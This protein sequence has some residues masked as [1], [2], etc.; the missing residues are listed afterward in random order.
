[1]TRT[2]TAKAARSRDG[3]PATRT[4]TTEDGSAHTIP[5]DPPTATVI[6]AYRDGSERREVAI[7]PLEGGDWSVTDGA[8]GRNGV[9]VEVETLAGFSEDA[10][11]E[12]VALAADYLHVAAENPDRRVR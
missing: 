7:E 6:G 11:S 8:G 5:I 3:A 4:V 12:A 1:M 10:L 9:R 2:A